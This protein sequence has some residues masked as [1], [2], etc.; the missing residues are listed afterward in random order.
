MGI[1]SILSFSGYFVFGIPI[2][3]F[4][5]FYKDMGITGIWIGPTF[6]CIFL[7]VC[8]NIVI[9]RTDLQFIVNQIQERTRLERE[10]KAKLD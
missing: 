10:V 6:A 1:G 5:A 8:Y 7:F 3:W 2:A 4:F 9:S